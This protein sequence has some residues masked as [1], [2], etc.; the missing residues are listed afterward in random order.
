MSD[1]IHITKLVKAMLNIG[2]YEETTERRLAVLASEIGG[3]NDID[4]KERAVI[5]EMFFEEVNRISESGEVTF[6]ALAS[7]DKD[8]PRGRTRCDVKELLGFGNT[9][10]VYAVEVEGKPLALKL[11]SARHIK[12]IVRVHGKFGLGG[13]LVELDKQDRP[14]VLSDLGQR[15][16]SKKPKGIYARNKRIVKVHTVGVEGGIMYILMDLLDVDPISRINTEAMGADLADLVAW[17]IDCV[18]GLCHLHIE[19]RRLHLNIRPEAFIRQTV[20]EARIPKY[21]FFSYPKKIHRPEG[22]PSEQY[23]FIMV[24]HLDNSVEIDDASPK[25]L[26]TVGSWLYLSPECV[27]HLVQT[28]RDDYKKYVERKERIMSVESIR[29]KRT[30]LDDVWALGL[31]LY[32]IFTGGKSPFGETKTLG[33]MV[34]QVLLSKIDLS[35]V[36]PRV[37]HVLGAMLEKDPKKRYQRVLEGC[38]E[39]VVSKGVLAEALL[40]KFEDVSLRLAG[41]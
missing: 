40:Y 22:G 33:D 18:V 14:T 25:G 26:M 36:D 39:K 15:V 17:A 3:F 29:M 37:S 12:E 7:G 27:L 6:T 41:S 2:L 21:T 9:G 8:V 10:P 13:I 38:P 19:E 5:Q 16:L 11:Y 4:R 32:P 30:Q 23:E 28:L 20:R 24:D 34:N 31:T 1:K 35:D